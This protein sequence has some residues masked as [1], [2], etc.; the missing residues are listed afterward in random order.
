MTAGSRVI[1]DGQT[2]C[3]EVKADEK[4]HIKYSNGY[5]NDVDCQEILEYFL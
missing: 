1:A 3:H 5:N 4:L 2:G